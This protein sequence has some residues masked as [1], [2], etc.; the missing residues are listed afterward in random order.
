MPLQHIITRTLTDP[1]PEDVWRWIA[2]RAT[3]H[4]HRFPHQPMVDGQRSNRKVMQV[5]SKEAGKNMTKNDT[6]SV[7]RHRLFTF[8]NVDLD[9][10]GRKPEIGSNFSVNFIESDRIEVAICQ[11]ALFCSSEPSNIALYR[12]LLILSENNS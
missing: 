1:G 11:S 8:I 12:C 5:C 6:Q 3:R 7:N 9:R 10:R 4:R 2:L